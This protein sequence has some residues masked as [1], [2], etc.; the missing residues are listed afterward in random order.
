MIGMSSMK[1]KFY[2]GLIF[3]LNIIEFIVS[4]LLIVLLYFGIL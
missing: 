2:F 1:P 4:I 3:I